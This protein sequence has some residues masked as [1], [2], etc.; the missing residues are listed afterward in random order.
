M[1]LAKVKLGSS[2][3][4]VTQVCLGTMT[5]GIQNNEAEAFEQLDY[6]VLER[7]VN[8]IDT[9][10]GTLASFLCL[11]VFFLRD[12]AFLWI[13]L[14]GDVDVSASTECVSDHCRM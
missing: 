7:G 11:F 3:L 2:D 4:E 9:A 12:R 8:F 14:A 6:A 5:F 1:G 10:E 13:G